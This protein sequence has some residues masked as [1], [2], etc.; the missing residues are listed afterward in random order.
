MD[1]EADVN[2]NKAMIERFAAG[3]GVLTLSPTMSD[4][5]ILKLVKLACSWSQGKV[6]QVVP[7][8]RSASPLNLRSDSLGQPFVSANFRKEDAD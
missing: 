3:G 7:P 5:Q 4:D 1:Q 2:F 8:I 6:F